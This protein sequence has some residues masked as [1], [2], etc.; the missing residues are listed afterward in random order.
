MGFLTCR[1]FE[2]CTTDRT[3]TTADNP[4][5]AAGD[6]LPLAFWAVSMV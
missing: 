2:F 1:I 3:K 5:R 4:T 6:T